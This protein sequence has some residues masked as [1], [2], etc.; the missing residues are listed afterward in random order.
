MRLWNFIS[1]QVYALWNYR[2]N[3]TGSLRTFTRS[4]GIHFWGHSGDPYENTEVNYQ[5]TRQLYRNAGS[6]SLGAGF[7]KPIV[8]LQVSF[9]AIPS[10]T[11]DDEDQA[12][13]LNECLH[14]Y[15]I[16]E[17]QQMLR[18][19]LRDSKTVVRI[20]RPDILDPLMTLEERE[21]CSLEVI[22]PERVEIERRLSNKN[23][24]ERAVVMHR[25]TFV[26]DDGDPERGTDPT[27]EEHEV[28]EIITRE[29]FR[30]Y[31]KTD[32]VELTD[33]R[34]ENRWGFVPLVEVFNEWD[35]ALQGGISEYETSLPFIKALHD[36]LFQGL[37]AHKYHSMPKV[38][39][40]VND[41]YSFLK[42]NY[43]EAIDETGNI[44]SQVEI[45]WKGREVFFLQTEEDV[46]FIEARNVLDGTV[47]LAE[48]LIDC[49]CIASETPEWA[50]MRTQQGNQDAEKNAQT[51][52]F[53]KKIDRKR[54]IFTKPIQEI[55]KMVQVING[56]IPYR[57]KL[58]WDFVRAEEHLTRMQALQMLIMGLEVAK[59]SGEISDETY[60][61]MLRMF[62]PVMKS[63]TQEAADALENQPSA[64]AS[65]NGSKPGTKN[66]PAIGAGQQ[67]ENE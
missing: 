39:L 32:N 34:A 16:D 26:V 61:Q 41:I 33:L 3:L 62:I 45:S 24:I 49:I 43:P 35:S 53:V 20:H 17:I 59:Q 8:D 36:L 64:L 9:M 38:K 23:I 54:N 51:V 13:F 58:T 19:S 31:D 57:A 60:R 52:P 55:L 10:V 18:D 14:I 42:N 65:A 50:F 28:M 30:F 40:Q 7:C 22:I 29:N 56:G 11:L 27:V 37:L 67:G 12:D 44:K 25:M 15:W 4:L 47:V 21:H 6:T 48:F 46:T 1:E 5:E 2:P 63:P 66:V